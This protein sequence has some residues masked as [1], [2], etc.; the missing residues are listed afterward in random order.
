VS[1][2]AMSSGQGLREFDAVEKYYLPMCDFTFLIDWPSVLD[3]YTYFT[4]YL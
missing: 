2:L 4:L 1:T 3:F